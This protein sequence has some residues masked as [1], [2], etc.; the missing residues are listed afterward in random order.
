MFPSIMRFSLAT[1]LTVG[2]SAAVA[3]PVTYELDPSHSF[4]GFSYP[5]IGLSTQQQRFNGA[6]GTIVL[7]TDAKTGS[8]DV[9][10]DTTSIT[11]GHDGFDK[12]IQGPE[13]LDT[14]AHPTATFKSSKVIFEGDKPVAAEGDLTIKGVT[15]PVTLKLTSFA[16]K[17]HPM[18]KKPAIGANATAVIKRSE[19]NASKF[20]PAVSDDVTLVLVVEAIAP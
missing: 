13:F 18:A 9:T 11:T 8:V 6:K 14:A 12:H 19:F 2:M 3:A 5:H 20:V 7:D 1:A 10:V 4:A 16:S 17:E 15:K